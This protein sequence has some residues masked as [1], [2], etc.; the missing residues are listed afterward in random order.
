MQYEAEIDEPYIRKQCENLSE[1]WANSIQ[2]ILEEYTLAQLSSFQKCKNVSVSVKK[3][4]YVIPSSR[5]GFSLKKKQ[6]PL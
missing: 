2:C 6:N 4:A 3:S 1:V 5:S